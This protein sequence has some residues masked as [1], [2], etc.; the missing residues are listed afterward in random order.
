MDILGYNLEN[1]KRLF[2]QK[3][4]FSNLNSNVKKC[5]NGLKGVSVTVFEVYFGGGDNAKWVEKWKVC[6]TCGWKDEKD[7]A[8]FISTGDPFKE[9]NSTQEIIKE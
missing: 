4:K 1:L 5:S 7:D 2:I 8:S 9:Q 3:L 6:C